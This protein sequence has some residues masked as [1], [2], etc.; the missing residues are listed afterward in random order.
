M[1][2]GSCGYCHHDHWTHKWHQD[3]V[4]K[5]LHDSRL[6]KALGSLRAPL[7]GIGVEMKQLHDYQTYP[8]ADHYLDL[9][10]D[11]GPEF[12]SHNVGFQP[13]EYDLARQDFLQIR[14]RL[15][16]SIWEHCYSKTRPAL[17]R[18]LGELL[19]VEDTSLVKFGFGSNVT[20]VVARLIAS[21]S[22]E[23]NLANYTVIMAQD[24][25]V[26]L[27]RAAVSL[28][29]RGAIIQQTRSDKLADTVEGIVL[30]KSKEMK[31]DAHD[32]TII[33]VSLVNSCTQKVQSLDWVANLPPSLVVIIDV[34]Q[35]VANVP[36]SDYGIGNLAVKPNVFVV[37]SLIKHARCGEGVGFLTCA[38]STGNLIH[39]PDS[40]WA[41]FLTGLRT[42]TTVDFD[43]NRPLYDK[44]LEWSGGT[45]GWVEPAYVATRVLKVMPNVRTQHRYV[46]GLKQRFVDKVRPLLSPEQSAHAMGSDSNTV[47]IPLPR[48][49]IDPLPFGLDYKVVNGTTYLRCGF[50][51]HNLPYHVDTLVA[52][53]KELAIFS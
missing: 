28:A 36:L 52:T 44:G 42:N 30:V 38:T 22:V 18:E 41:S 4:L 46:Q 25:F 31:Q 2:D 13:R 12:G 35:A 16:T 29:R 32:G 49:P 23:C 9:F 34:T 7:S 53:L 51:V 8:L 21:F 47:A 3:R 17:C 20:E 27:Q 33:F 48:Q 15:R 19:D 39:D 6:L 14:R 10:D 24:E 1:L 37:G 45:P 40:G 5:R 50:G 11:P 26:T 43:K